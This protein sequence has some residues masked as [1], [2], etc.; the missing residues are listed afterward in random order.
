MKFIELVAT[1]LKL[2]RLERELAENSKPDQ[3]IHEQP[4]QDK[5]YTTGPVLKDGRWVFVDTEI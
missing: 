4:K 5:H 1:K 3:I 2:T